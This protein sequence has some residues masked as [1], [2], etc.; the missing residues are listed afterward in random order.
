MQKQKN[1][2]KIGKIKGQMNSPFE[3]L[4][5]MVIIVFVIL[6]GSQMLAYAGNK[7]CENGV[8]SEISEFKT[9]LEDAANG[10]SSK[11]FTFYPDN[12]CF[13]KSKA[14]IK[15]QRLSTQR[16]CSAICGKPTDACWVLIFNSNES[17]DGIFL[18]RC[19]AL[20]SYT[21]FLTDSTNCSTADKE[22][23][24][25]YNVLDPTQIMPLGKYILRNVAG[26][27]ESLPKICTFQKVM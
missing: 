3:L 19:L 25:G 13:D 10:R 26:V 20:H 17:K 14:I 21:S 9:N 7:T 11:E 22:E 24:D 4:V 8:N 12:V 6:L 5:T 1:L 16:E 18:Q 27:G 2:K 23:L 15:L